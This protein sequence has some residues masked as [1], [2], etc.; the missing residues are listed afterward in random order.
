MK[1]QLFN[2]FVNYFV[3]IL[4]FGAVDGAK[5]IGRSLAL[6]SCSTIVPLTLPL[7]MI[8]PVSKAIASEQTPR[9]TPE[10]I[11]KPA[12][13][14]ISRIFDAKGELVGVATFLQT[15][16]GVQVSLQVR[17]L[18][19]G[20]HMVHIHEIGKCDAPDFSTSGRHFDP[21]GIHTDGKRSPHL[22]HK[23]EMPKDPK[24]DAH[25]AH[26]P[27]GDLPNMMVM[28]N[29]AGSLVAMLPNLTLG[30]GANSLLKQG[31]TSILI[32]AGANGKSTIPNVDYK[33]RIACG[34]IQAQ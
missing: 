7:T 25:S 4:N 13:N 32:H 16:M 17:N 22:H 26:T 27:A 23:H 5:W 21:Q 18:A 8:F 10:Q 6:F 9:Q 1:A 2:Y 30:I 34:V 3:N 29:G 11:S 19:K 28:S 14:A 31:G 20:E 12:S 15:N 24:Q 33:T